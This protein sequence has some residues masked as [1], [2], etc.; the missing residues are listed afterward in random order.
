MSVRQDITLPLTPG[1]IVARLAGTNLAVATLIVGTDP[2]GS[3]LLRVGGGAR[4][5]GAIYVLPNSGTGISLGSA[6]YASSA[7]VTAYGNLIQVKNYG[8]GGYAAVFIGNSSI[9][10]GFGIDPSTVAGGQFGGNSTDIFFRRGGN[11]IV[12]NAGSTNWEH[13]LTI[14]GGSATLGTP[15][16]DIS[17][18]GVTLGDAVNIIINA[19]TGTKIGTATT[20]KLSLWNATPVVQPA[21]A[22]QAAVAGTAATNTAPYGFTTSAQADGIVTLLN[23]LRAAL[24]TIGAIKGAA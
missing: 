19:T 21:S 17:A 1:Q 5:N 22:N 6:G 23:E 14:S 16:L 8:Y 24:V 18:S 12:P 11:F 4:V 3:E 20:Q 9:G 7:I 10:T 2:G 15:V 13:A